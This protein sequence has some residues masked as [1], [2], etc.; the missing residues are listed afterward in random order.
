[1]R[2]RS[3]CRG[4]NAEIVWCTTLAGKNIPVDPEP[5]AEGNLVFTIGMKVRHAA[6]GSQ[7]KMWRSHFVTC[8]KR[9]EFRRPR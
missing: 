7:E 4:C 2:P 6:V 3:V 9:D 1:M 8:P 5:H